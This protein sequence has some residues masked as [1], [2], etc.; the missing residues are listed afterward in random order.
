MLDLIW[1]SLCVILAMFLM[2][3][4]LIPKNIYLILFEKYKKFAKDHKNVA[5]VLRFVICGGIATVVD[6]FVMGVVM[7]FMQPSIY[8]TFLNVFINTPTP[9]TIA[10]VVGT[11]V[12][13]V[14]GLLV[15]YV[16]SILFVFNEKGTSKSTKGF[17]IFTVLSVIGLGINLAGMYIGFD[18]LG[19]NQWLVKIIVTIIVLI[20]NY[21]SKR[22]LLFRK[23]PKEVKK[24]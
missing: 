22:L 19:W 23:N 12:G 20:Y 17:I 7:Y 4:L 1:L 24:D 2:V 11:G 3:L 10:T 6:M 18:L 13:F 8:P 21:V 14:V 16:L 15:N 5:E 9:S